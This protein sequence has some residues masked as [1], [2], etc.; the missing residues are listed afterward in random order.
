MLVQEVLRTDT[1][2]SKRLLYFRQILWSL[3][4]LQFIER[5]AAKLDIFRAN[6]PPIVAHLV[7]VQVMDSIESS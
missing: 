7:N 6:N 5:S 4:A 1:A 3:I 2:R